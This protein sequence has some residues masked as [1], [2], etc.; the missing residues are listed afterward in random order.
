[1][2]NRHFDWFKKHETEDEVQHKLQRLYALACERLAIKPDKG[3]IAA[4][5]AA[6]PD[7]ARRDP[8]R[9]VAHH[10]FTYKLAMP[11]GAWGLLGLGLL[12]SVL[13][14]VG[15]EDG[16]KPAP[17]RIARTDAHDL[18][19]LAG[20]LLMPEVD[21]KDVRRAAAF[22]EYL[23]KAKGPRG[24]LKF[25]RKMGANG[26]V[27]AACEAVAGVSTGALELKWQ[28]E[29]RAG[30]PERG[31][32]HL[33][34][35]VAKAAARH[36]MLLFWFL[37]ANAVQILYAVY[38]PLWL[39]TLFDEGIKPSNVEVIRTY[40]GYLIWGFL[41]ASFFGVILD[42]SVAKLGPRILNDLRARM[43]SKINRMDARELASSDT[44]AIIAD[45]SNDLTVVEKAVIWAVPGL[46]S[47]GLMLIGSVAVAFTLDTQLAIATLVSLMIAFWLPRGFSKRAVRYNYERGAEDAKV[48][49]VVKETLLMQRVIRIFGLHDLQSKL[50]TT[51]LARLFKASYHQYFSSGLVG[52]MTSFGVSAAQLLVIGLGA[53]QSV[54][55]DVSSGTI[56]A[57]ITLLLTIGGAAGFIGAQLP[58]LI[59]G[60]GGLERVQAL[61][62]KPDAAP[63]PERP[64]NIGG[65]VHS[66]TFDEVSF[67]YDGTATTLDKV[68]LSIDCPRRV[69]VVGPS[70]SGKSTILRLIENQFSPRSGHVRVNGVDIRMLGE[71]QLRSLISL[72]PQETILFQGSVRENIRMGKLGASDAEVEAAAKAADIHPIIM[73]LPD[74]YDTDVG[75]GGSKL[76]GGQ[77]QRIAIA[78]AILHDP[79]IMLLDEATSALDPASRVAVEETLRKVTKGRT[80]VAVTHDLTQCE[81]A[82]LVYVVKAGRVVE[83]GTHAALLEAEG[84]YA[85]LWERSV[86]AGA[87]G[88]VP[89][90]QL[91]ERLRKRP[92]LQGLAP[93]FL[94]NLLAR[95]SVETVGPD[96][97]LIEDG[98]PADRLIFITQGEAQQSVRLP[99]GTFMS[100]E[101]LEAGDALGENTVLEH[102][103][104]FTRVVTRKP[105]HLLTIDR[106]TLRALLAAH[107]DV[108]Q[109][110]VSTFAPRYE[111]MM[112]HYA[113]L[114]LQV[115]SQ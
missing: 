10:L 33:V 52:R 93:G 15:R 91:L 103:E 58:L 63:D 37:V 80:V 29:I 2:S 55:G 3:F 84:V 88:V 100:V 57:F 81:H 114:K 28:D 6:N 54:H 13:L 75:E 74:G 39:Q 40:I 27:D 30:T 69:M 49:H 32:T 67:S 8:V 44:D 9:R 87:E 65:K 45:F 20:R 85:D 97:V 90:E 1:M 96:T 101:V 108:E 22:V 35:W 21:Q 12:H 105:C 4:A 102:A 47:K 68:S 76:S 24:F 17:V 38:V 110:I 16:K 50:F 62:G 5:M 53:L 51:Q 98:R 99:D 92:L 70:G 43:F 25:G 61:L 71:A 64:E 111:A 107:P 72:V 79:Q 115:P 26:N 95:M 14:E 89:R 60:V 46:F 59:Q 83:S 66:L 18:N 36:K 11:S 77:R 41:A 113:W 31:P 23:L 48:A 34:I 106:A 78:R 112:K 56:V 7:E 82:D 109:K 86:I 94:E 73:A 19:G 42:Y 104:E